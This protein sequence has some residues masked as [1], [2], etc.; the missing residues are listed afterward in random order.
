MANEVYFYIIFPFVIHPLTRN[1]V[2]A[3]LSVSCSLYLAFFVFNNMP[4]IHQQYFPMYIGEY[5]PGFGYYYFITHLPE[6]LM[7][8][9]VFRV[10]G[11]WAEFKPWISFVLLCVSCSLIL[12]EVFVSYRQI[13]PHWPISLGFAFLLLRLR[14]FS[15]P[16]RFMPAGRLTSTVLSYCGQ[17]SYALFLTRIPIAKL[18][19]FFVG[20][21]SVS[22]TG[23][24]YISA[25]FFFI[26]LF[27][28][29]LVHFIFHPVDNFFVAIGNQF[30]SRIHGK[31][32]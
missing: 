26:V 16:T 8:V 3:T 6:F 25:N 14:S 31:R 17:R 9:L 29:P 20:T 21:H 11:K 18:V 22:D 7:G 28:L 30:L 23:W 2:T 10:E 24:G 15:V 5:A 4:M 27:T 1:T 12:S 32:R 13:S 19:S